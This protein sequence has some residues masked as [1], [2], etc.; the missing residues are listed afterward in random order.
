[1]FTGLV[2]ETGIIKSVSPLGRGKKIVVQ[3]SL[4]LE[5]VKLGDSINVSGVCQTV[6][7]AGK[8]EFSV[9]AVEET[10]SKTN[11][12]FLQAGSIVNL[13]RS[14]LPSTRLGGHFVSGHTDTRGR[15]IS[16]EKLTASHI[17][18]ISFDSRFNRNVIPVGSI[19][20]EGISLTVAEKGDG[21]VKVAVIPHT[22]K[23]TNLAVKKAGDPVNLEF[24]LLG[25]Y[26]LNAQTAEPSGQITEARLREMG[27]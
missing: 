15:I 2:E 22:W 24:D 23:M 21:M 3:A 6:V 4:V 12:E 16:I 5:D 18:T 14:L 10:L 1:M 20:I 26:I 19:A 17:M 13:E 7:S 11:F 27:Y 8:N 25:K 9:E